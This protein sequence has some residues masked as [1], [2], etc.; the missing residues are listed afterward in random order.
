MTVG[1]QNVDHKIDGDT[2]E[3]IDAITEHESFTQSESIPKEW[4]QNQINLSIIDESSTESLAQ[5]N[6]FAVN[7]SH[8]NSEDN[9]DCVMCTYFETTGY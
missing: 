1:S 7:P 6:I 5:T 3:N 9:T 2:N 4:L 8:R